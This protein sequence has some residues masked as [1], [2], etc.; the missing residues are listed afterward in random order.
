MARWRERPVRRLRRALANTVV[1]QMLP[2]GVVKG[3]TAMKVRVGE[4]GSRFTPDLDAAV[5]WANELISRS[6]Q[7]SDEG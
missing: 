3:G 6:T 7:A 5:S 2:P 4:A 1:G